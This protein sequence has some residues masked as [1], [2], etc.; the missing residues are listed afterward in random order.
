MTPTELQAR[1]EELERGI[2]EA[3]ERATCGYGRID[4]EP[5]LAVLRPLL[6]PAKAA[7]PRVD[8]LAVAA[9]LDKYED[10]ANPA[11]EPAR[12]RRMQGNPMCGHEYHAAEHDETERC[13][14]YPACIPV[15]GA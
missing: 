13:K 5:I 6:A 12:P 10:Q 15:E 9:A 11:K 4:R 3:I 1:V 14:D 8:L 2:G 7:A